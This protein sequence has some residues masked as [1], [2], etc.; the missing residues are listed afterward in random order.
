[1]GCERPS[2]EWRGEFPSLGR[3]VWLNT[4]HQ[5][6]LPQ[7]AAAAAREAIRWKERPW[8][9]TT[10]RFGSV[11]ATLLDRLARLLD[12]PHDEI[13]LANSS[14]YGVH[15]L[16]NGI[17]W[18]AGDEVLVVRGDFPSTFLP[19]TGLGPRGVSVRFL[20]P[21]SAIL[22]V[23]DVEASL[24]K[25]TRLLCTTWVHSFQGQVIDVES[26]GALCRDR[27][28]LFV[29]N[30]S[31]GIGA[32]PLHP[33][34]LPLDALTSVGFKWLCGPYGTGF[35]WIRGE[36]LARLEYNQHYWLSHATADDLAGD[37]EIDPSSDLGGRRYDLFGTAN[38]F[39]FHAWSAA[40][41]VIL[42][43]GV[44][45][46]HARNQLLVDRLLRGLDK[47][48]FEVHSPRDESSRSS[49]VFASH[50]RLESNDSVQRRLRE[51]GVE[52][53][54]RRHRL[55][56]SPHFYNTFDDIDA[57]L[58]VLGELWGPKGVG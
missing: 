41:D 21:E 10:A 24:R 1:M 25:E 51:A 36:L 7:T 29:L 49:L 53:A 35:C 8:E 28:V 19:W 23:D 17:P 12:V 54:L 56:L 30:A 15:L 39:N 46:I 27:G 9:L 42:E 52:V 2:P 22:S 5:G 33:S 43:H 38:F 37:F 50:P 31:Q 6:V 40:L 18:R 3:R 57:A 26:I 14:S 34:G 47:I 58:E 16:A 32:R 44:T 4:A 13:V 20:E 45:A 48:C 11:P 55:R